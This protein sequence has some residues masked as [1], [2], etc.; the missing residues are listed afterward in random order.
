MTERPTTFRY[1]WVDADPTSQSLVP[2]STWWWSQQYAAAGI[3]KELEAFNSPQSLQLYITHGEDD[4]FV[5][6]SNVAAACAW[7]R[8]AFSQEIRS[9]QE[10]RQPATSSSLG[11]ALFGVCSQLSVAEDFV[12]ESASDESPPAGTEAAEASTRPRDLGDCL[13]HDETSKVQY[14]HGD[15][16]SQLA[17]HNPWRWSYLRSP[18]QAAKELDEQPRARKVLLRV[19]SST[20]RL[21][22]MFPSPASAAVWIRRR[23]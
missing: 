15:L 11:S 22:K 16:Y 20:Q 14:M 13:T 23:L 21:Q 17:R 5:Q 12:P 1:A 2:S 3:V 4:L 9:G 6:C 18:E 10:E 19:A 8:E 7:L